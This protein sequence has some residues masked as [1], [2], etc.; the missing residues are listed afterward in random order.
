MAR[1]IRLERRDGVIQRYRTTPKGLAKKGYVKMTRRVRGREVIVWS[2]PR[3]PPVEVPTIFEI[4]PEEVPVP[5]EAEAEEPTGFY[6]VVIYTE[7]RQK[8]HTYTERYELRTVVEARSPE[9]AQEKSLGQFLRF[10]PDAYRDF[11]DALG[12]FGPDVS[13]GVH[14]ISVVDSYR[15]VKY[16]RFH[17]GG[18][19]P[20]EALKHFD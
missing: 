12:I 11:L 5:V 7:Y 9:E 10:L 14:R 19:R 17:V 1:L 16:Y 18:V 13:E 2:K 20:R 3:E 15:G 8:K 4:P 6:E